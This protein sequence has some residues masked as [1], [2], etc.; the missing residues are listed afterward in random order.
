[1]LRYLAPTEPGEYRIEYSIFSTGAPQLADTATV[2]VTVIDDES[3]RAPRPETLEGRVLSGQQTVIG[4]DRFGVDPDGDRVE[5]DRI[6]TQPAAGSATI[7]ADGESIVYT[8]VP[9]DSGQRSFEYT[10]TDTSGASGT[11]IVRIG[12]LDQESN[13][14]P[15]TFT[16]YIQVQA[17]DDSSIRVSPLANDIDPTGGRLTLTD[18]RP[19]LAETLGDGSE[20]PEFDRQ[21]RLIG[22]TDGSTVVMRAG[23]QPGTMSF[24][25]DVRSD[26]GNTARGLIVV[27]VVRE[28]VPDFPIVADTLLTAET[29]A[30]FATGVDVVSGMVAWSGGD[31]DELSLSLWGSPSGVSVTGRRIS[32]GLPERT[33]II[34]F[35]L[36]G[37]SSSGEKVTTY[38]F[39][40]VPG[41]DDYT[42]AL[43][44]G[45]AAQEVTERESVEFDMRTLVA[46]PQGE[47][48]EVGA[49]VAP[50]GARKGATC[51]V[52]EG[53]K[54][55]YDAAEGAPWA[56]GCTVP[57]RVAGQKD[58]TFLSVPVRITAVAPQPELHPASLTVGPGEKATFDLKEGM[59][60]WQWK[61]DWSSVAYSLEYAGSAFSVS[62]ADDGIV[63]I[64]G[65]D[66]A[67]P[68]TEEA[69]TVG[70][71]SH[72]GVAP[73]R[74][75]LRV[76]A[77][78]STLPQGGTVTKLCSQASGSS[79]TITVVGAPGEVNP[80]PGTPLELTDV[81]ATGA[82]VGVSFKRGSASTVV[83]SWTGD[84]PGATCTASFSVRDAQK[85]DT[86]GDRDGSLLLD[87]QGYPKAPAALTQS[88]YSDGS[89]TLRVDPGEA[90][91]AYPAL[92]GFVVRWN[93][94]VVA[95]CS[96]DGTCPAIAAP[97]GEKRVY[98]A[99]AINRVGE[100]KASVRTTAWAYDAPPA[101]SGV[102]ATP[103]VT[104]GDGRIVDLAVS[105]IDPS[106]VGYLEVKSDTGETRR[107]D[108][109]RNTT[110]VVPR[111]NVGTNSA[112]IVTVTPFSRFEMPPGFD[113]A[114]SGSAVTVRTNGIGAPLSPSLV[115]TSTSNG[116]GTS[117]IVADGTA[118]LNGD[119]SRL[120]YGFVAGTN[121]NACRV[122]DAG[123]RA[124]F[125]VTDGVEYPY[126]MC[127]EA[128]Y[129]SQS[130]GRVTVTDTVR[131]VQSTNAP[132][133]FTFVVDGRP[134]P[135][136]DSASWIIR[137]DPSSSAT[138]PRN[139]I[140]VFENGPPTGVFGRD[141]NIRVYWQHRFWG[142]TSEGA[143]VRPAA[144]SAPYQVTAS[145]GV[146]AC[147]GGEALQLRSASSNAPDGSKAAITF[148]RAA[149]R[150]FDA[151]GTEL[152]HEDSWLV[153]VG[154][155]RVQGV[156]VTVDWSAQNWGLQ[157]ATD[158]FSGTCT[159]NLPPDDGAGG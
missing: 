10:V 90:R 33:E 1:V 5:L 101:P 29:R 96:A 80:L 115:L 140:A 114:T 91:Q 94:A 56:D 75:I 156:G 65:E 104:G 54:I 89:L 7:S 100:S 8:S 92:T 14:S 136:D 111:Y 107:V 62:L 17:G 32:G 138:P 81:R 69:A 49:D 122:G 48:L 128:W 23:T 134:E 159:P 74:L 78:P 63:T 110:A 83:A 105:G 51:R 45:V 19:D 9:G 37:L 38:G 27:K 42:L 88:K 123:P 126:V 157:N 6:V 52:T 130:F 109:G 116:D 142:T 73:A 125:T 16:D 151:D 117:T 150:Y 132:T 67:V 97:N 68:G 3:N 139:N 131:A 21:E 133:G 35:A 22:D 64:T 141:P 11:G 158:R 50:S 102:S 15:V 148:D 76:G 60:S 13:P 85:R 121:E 47:E 2:R 58:W 34:P 99:W 41:E 149:L 43:R 129:D 137:N 95:E 79:C 143:R 28:S 31:V 24:L 57:V 36:S 61:T 59:T 144:G 4:F 103:V 84:A 55:R 25:Y 152:P 154:A 98:Q 106:E 77:A 39:L 108:V 53:T 66:A 155:V 118:A 70:I 18:I 146:S 124:T 153:P 135:G 113:G 12:V 40:R 147:K 112:T 127:V 30:Q 44:K 26:S 20:S 145:W 46:Y 87:L 120:R 119:G 71:T 82:C 86:A 93:G 72:P